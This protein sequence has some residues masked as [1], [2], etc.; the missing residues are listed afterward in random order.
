[1]T[2]GLVPPTLPDR[3]PTLP[4]SRRRGSDQGRG[5]LLT[6]SP[7]GLAADLVGEPSRRDG[8]QPNP[9][10]CSARRRRALLRRSEQGLLGGVFARVGVPVATNQR[11]DDQRPELA[12]LV[13]DTQSNS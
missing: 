12:E 9:A 8:G 6:A 7:G 4:R 11:A 1:M 3:R 5:C 2:F 13:L 10:G